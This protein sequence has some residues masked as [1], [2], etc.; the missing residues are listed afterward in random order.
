MT[1]EERIASVQLG[2]YV[3]GVHGIHM[4]KRIFTIA[5]NYGFEYEF[6]I[7]QI[8][9]L[10]EKEERGLQTPYIPGQ[11]ALDLENLIDYYL[12]D[13]MPVDQAYWGRNENRDWGLWKIDN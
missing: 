7:P 12:N 13:K 2:C 4:W 8:E 6:T 1:L 5:K 10:I 11:L 9:A 3:D